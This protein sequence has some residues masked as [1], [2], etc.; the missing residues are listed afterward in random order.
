MRLPVLPSDTI[1][2]EPLHATMSAL[3]R[4]VVSTRRRR[5]PGC[6][7][8]QMGAAVRAALGVAEPTRFAGTR[9]TQAMFG[10]AHRGADTARNSRA[11]RRA[12]AEL[13]RR[14]YTHLGSWGA[15]AARVGVTVETIERAARGVA[16]N[17]TCVR[18]AASLA[19]S[20]E[21]RAT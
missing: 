11:E 4:A 9:T 10:G 17:A 21:M 14:M 20:P 7:T 8:C 19:A 2:C 5:Q 16:S 6:V 1:K 12:N 18:I 13:L 15:V 3:A